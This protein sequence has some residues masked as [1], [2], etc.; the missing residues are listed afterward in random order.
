MPTPIITDATTDRVPHAPRVVLAAGAAMFTQR[1]R[2]FAQLAPGH[3]LQGFLTLMAQIASAQA[4]AWERRAPPPVDEH[5]LAASRN[6]GMPPLADATHSRGVSWLDDLDDILH[7]LEQAPLARAAD[8][9]IAALRIASPAALDEAADRLLAGASLDEEGAQVPLLGAA[10]Q[11]HFT[12]IAASLDVSA[13]QASDVPEL[14]PVC[15][16]RPVAG[17]VHTGGDRANLR[18]LVCSLCNTEWNLPRVTCS[19][20]QD[21]AGLQYLA[22]Q[23]ADTPDGSRLAGAGAPGQAAN[24][25]WQAEACDSCQSYLKIFLQDKDPQVDA[26]ADDLA[27]LTLDVLVDEQ[28]YLRSG[29][30]LLFHPGACQAP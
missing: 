11:V 29:P 15:A 14:C 12:R 6:H 8:G 20:C 28:G 21:D 4:G 19:S 1:A 25:A 5:L 26:L 16:S 13:V 9:A 17:I 3:P 27:S 7:L 10:L 2:R 23:G 22:L 18:Y 30:N 24:A